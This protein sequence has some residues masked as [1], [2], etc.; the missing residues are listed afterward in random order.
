MKVI[1]QQEFDS[2]ILL[3]D[4]LVKTQFEI[5]D[6]TLIGNGVGVSDG[7]FVIGLGY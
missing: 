3:Y 4:L 5:E 2:S 1:V 6:G 7:S